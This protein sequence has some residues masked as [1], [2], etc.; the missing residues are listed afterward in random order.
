MHAD[1]TARTPP[2]TRYAEIGGVATE[3]WGCDPR[4][5]RSVIIISYCEEGKAEIRG[6][7]YNA[8]DPGECYYNTRPE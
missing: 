4:S 6:Y 5:I 7:K 8:P 3:K 2:T 1:T